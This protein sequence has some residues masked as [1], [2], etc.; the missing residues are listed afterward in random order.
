[1]LLADTVLEHDG[2]AIAPGFCSARRQAPSSLTTGSE[3]RLPKPYV[4]TS[5]RDRVS[6]DAPLPVRVISTIVASRI[7]DVV[8]N[9]RLFHREQP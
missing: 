3:S 6:S 8:H 2:V 5:E 1:M 9:R 7:G 4:E